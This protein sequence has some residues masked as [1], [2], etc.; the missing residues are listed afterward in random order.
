[1][2]SPATR[3]SQQAPHSPTGGGERNPGRIWAIENALAGIRLGP[4][5]TTARSDRAGTWA[6]Y[7]H[8]SDGTPAASYRQPLRL[9]ACGAWTLDAGSRPIAAM[10]GSPLASRP[11]HESS[12]RPRVRHLQQPAWPTRVIG[13]SRVKASPAPRTR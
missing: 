13:S 5:P 4:K 10:E 1:M 9:A 12:E 3:T 11:R 6:R 7:G 8:L 2:P